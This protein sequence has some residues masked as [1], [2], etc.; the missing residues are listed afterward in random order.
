VNKEFLSIFVGREVNIGLGR[1]GS[2][3]GLLLGAFESH[4]AV[5]TNSGKVMYIRNSHIKSISSSTRMNFTESGMTEDH[6]ME[7][8]SNELFADLLNSQIRQWVVI[9]QGGPDRVE[10]ILLDGNNDYVEISS[11]DEL[12]YMATK[13]IKNMTFGENFDTGRYM[14]TEEPE[15]RRRRR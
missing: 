3:Q 15:R 5:A 9:N 4:V 11:N 12:V 10:G 14:T 13:Q 8:D 7:F 2:L 6:G 1:T